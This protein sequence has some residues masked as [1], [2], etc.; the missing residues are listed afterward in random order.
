MKVNESHNHN[1]SGKNHH[2]RFH[3][4]HHSFYKAENYQKSIFG[5]IYI[6]SKAFFKA[7]NLKNQEI[8]FKSLGMNT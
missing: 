1:L 8:T 2:K 5:D 4:A 6:I 7:K 3:I